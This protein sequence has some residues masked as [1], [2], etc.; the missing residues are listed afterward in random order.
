MYHNTKVYLFLI[1]LSLSVVYFTKS[2][3]PILLFLVTY[4]ALF[5]LC[6]YLDIFPG[7][8]IWSQ[9]EIT[10]ECYQW[11]SHYLK[12][13]YGMLNGKMVYDLS[14]SLYMNDYKASAEK[15]LLN[16]YN[17]IFKQ[18]N[19]SKGK[20]LLDCGCGVGIWMAFCK[21]RG[22]DVVGLTLSEEQ[23]KTI[24]EKGMTA[25]VKDFRVF[26][27]QFIHQFDAISLLGPTEHVTEFEGFYKKTSLRDYSNLFKVLTQYL[28]PEGKMQ[29]TVLVQCRPRPERSGFYD[30]L[31]SYVMMRFYGGFYSTLSIIRQAITDNGLQID[32]VE[33]YTKDYHWISVAEPDHFG[34]WWVPWK[35]TPLDKVAYFVK[36]LCTDPY[37]IHRWLYYGLDTWMWQFG[38]YQKTPLTDEQVGHAIANLKYISIS[39][40]KA[41]T[42]EKK[43]YPAI[44]ELPS[45]FDS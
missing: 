8:K 29:L 15:A 19:L 44:H 23:Q 25:Y 11:F 24:A 42:I 16:K 9:K 40:P 39:K 12:K 36:G 18:L 6:E 33:D 20:R 3:Y 28:R 38:G 22:V 37:L 41:P 43:L 34:H 4:F 35:E 14:E 31:Q 27:R 10:T 21:E 1:L 32:T 26:D 13:D 45:L 2:S 17:L 7:F 30:R 5:I